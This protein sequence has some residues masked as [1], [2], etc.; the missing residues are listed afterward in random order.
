MPEWTPA[1]AY[2][3]RTLHTGRSNSNIIWMRICRRECTCVYLCDSVPFYNNSAYLTYIRASL[4]LTQKH[5]RMCSH[6]HTHTHASA[7]AQEDLVAHVYISCKALRKRARAHTH[8]HPLRAIKLLLFQF[9]QF[10][11]AH[12]LAHT[13]THQHIFD[14]SRCVRERAV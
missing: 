5:A 12:A 11:R 8:T 4:T 14:C 13:H 6:A 3:A 7:R 9:I 10:V 1:R 2:Y